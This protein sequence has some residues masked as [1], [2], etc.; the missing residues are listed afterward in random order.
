MVTPPS[1]SLIGSFRRHY[2][3][4]CR[5]AK[6]FIEAGIVVK[7]PPVSRIRDPQQEFVRFESDPPQLTDR[8]IQAATMEKIFSSDVVYVVNPGGYVG[9]GTSWELGRI[10]E[11]RM[12]VYYAEAPG[13]I[14]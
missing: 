13:E 4:V 3:E 6:I 8:A 10:R 1:V 5:V 14:L 7:S 2:D 11:R 12:P 9:P